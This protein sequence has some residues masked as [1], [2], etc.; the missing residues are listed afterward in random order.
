MARDRRKKATGPR[1]RRWVRW[2]LRAAIAGVA[3]AVVGAIV[4]AA[5]FY[6]YGRDP[7]LQLVRLDR[8]RPKAVT[9]VFDRK[10]RLIAELAAERRT[11][12]PYKRIPKL[13]VQ[14]VVSAEDADFFT[15]RGLDYTGMLRAF[16]A[17]LRAGR[18]VQGGSTITQQVVKTFFLTP[19]RTIK[20]KMQEVLLARRI[21]S[22]LGKKQ[23]LHLYL[24]QIYFGHGR[25]GVQE[26]SRF[27][28]GKNVEQLGLAEAAMLAGLPQAPER[29]SPLKHP[30]R[31]KRRQIYVLGEMARNSYIS[32]EVEK[33]VA[34][35]PLRVVRH[36]QPYLNQSPEVIDLVRS[37]LVAAY[38][39]D[40]LSTMGK[41]IHTTVD[42]ELQM[43]AREAVRVGL[44]AIDA[45]HG[46]RGRIRRVRPKRRARLLRRLARRQ[47]RIVEGRQ[48]LALVRSVDDKRQQVVAD[49]GDRAVKVN[50]DNARY[51][52][53]Q[54]APSKRFAGGDLIRIRA[55][56]QAFTFDPGPQAAM[57]VLEPKTGDVLAMVGG[58]DF[59]PGGFNRAVRA[60]RQPGS[61]FKPIVY[62]AALDTGRYT[63]A[64]IVDD[65]PVVFKGWE[66]RNFDG[67]YR[68][69]IRLRVA[70]AHSINTVAARLINDVGVAPVRRLATELGISTPLGEDLSL[71][72]GSSG[73][74]VIDL[75]AAYAA[76][77][78]G[79]ER[80]EPRYILRVAS[81][82]VKATPARRVLRPAV[83]HV[84]VSMMQ[85]VVQ[86]GT[87]RRARR[88]RRPVAGKTGTTNEQK[89][90]WFA[91][92]TPQLAAVV[93][94]GFDRPR[95][96]GRRETGGRAALPIW[97]DFMRR[98]LRR[99][100]RRS[101][102]Q[103][104]GVVVHRIDPKTGLLAHAEATDAIEEV[105]VQGTQPKEHAR[106]PDQVDPSTILMD[107]AVP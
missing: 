74:R 9:R 25:Y 55:R 45:R 85:S 39:E 48:Y 62:A 95:S 26:A 97:V 54:H 107:T 69:P 21:E 31:A 16:L 22:E 83:V 12:V 57:V 77:A 32:R 98:A 90:A 18:F 20:R 44:R 92:F 67:K 94:V 5:M 93:W 75:A 99:Q 53:Q 106:P 50:V 19:E 49:I 27:Y 33:T 15:H 36:N 64:T 30:K 78:N 6:H 1:P 88:L 66:P 41:A 59:S 61:A 80:I 11:V 10:Q 100:P 8:Y 14:A 2:L 104:P 58:Y 76:L 28:F 35:E 7:K 56:G 17:N 71:A 84:L 34:K 91:G 87:A 4:I 3:L 38:G 68:G 43:A 65:A 73:V 24:N 96:I 101:F 63:P 86:E 23:I 79:G 40:R 52:P 102:A 72:L 29:L 13:V 81:Q 105:F 89:D 60:T 103:P 47:K 51:N 70:L 42:V 37:Q 46:Y 82:P